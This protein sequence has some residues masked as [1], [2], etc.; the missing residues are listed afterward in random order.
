MTD[1]RLWDLLV[2][3]TQQEKAKKTEHN[4]AVNKVAAKKQ[5]HFQLE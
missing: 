5:W 3:L 1:E 2:S 4:N